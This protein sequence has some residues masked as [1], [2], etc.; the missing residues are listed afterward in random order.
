M[1][2]FQSKL[3]KKTTV[4]PI[5]QGWLMKVRYSI[6]LNIIDSKGRTAFSKNDREVQY[7][8]YHKKYIVYDPDL[9]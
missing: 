9:N 8:V 6:L 7:K 1:M 4:H 2:K 3:K 5:L